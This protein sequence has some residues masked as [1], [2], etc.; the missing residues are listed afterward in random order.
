M[1]ENSVSSRVG[2]SS[3]SVS[4]GRGV[5][6][7][8]RRG[9]VTMEGG[10]SFQCSLMVPDWWDAAELARVSGAWG[11]MV[12]R[13]GGGGRRGVGQGMVAFKACGGWRLV[14]LR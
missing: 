13:S 5:D 6:A 1:C 9:G 8:E 4:A 14:G 7:R 2:K 3:S 11:G 12:E 10:R